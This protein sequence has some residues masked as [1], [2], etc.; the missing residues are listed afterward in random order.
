MVLSDVRVPSHL[1]LLLLSRFPS[2]AYS[3]DYLDGRSSH[4]NQVSVSSYD[5][6]T[7][8]NNQ[9]RIPAHQQHLKDLRDLRD[10]MLPLAQIVRDIRCIPQ[11]SI[12]KLQTYHE[13]GIQVLGRASSFRASWSAL[14]RI[15]VS[16]PTR[17]QGSAA[18]F[19]WKLSAES[20]KGPDY[21]TVQLQNFRSINYVAFSEAQERG[22]T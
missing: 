5:P 4:Y 16:G 20:S 10:Q 22:P 12:A 11:R 17:C 8:I 7:A 2:V 14:V 19:T 18:G 13:A 9:P 1:P 6:S 3:S 15:L 21:E